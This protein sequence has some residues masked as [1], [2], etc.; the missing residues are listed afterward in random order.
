MSELAQLQRAFL[1][2]LQGVE[3]AS[4]PALLRRLPLEPAHGMTIYREHAQ[5][6]VHDAL[7]AGYPVV[8]RL[9]G[10]AFFAEMARRYGAAHPSHSGDLHAR[11]ERFCAF[12]ATDPP[13]AQLPY[14]S[15]MARLEWACE[16]SLRAADVPPL[17]RA[18]LRRVAPQRHGELRLTLH[19][20]VRLLPCAHA[21][22]A[23]WHAN[24]PGRDGACAPDAGPETILVWREGA[25][26]RVRPIDA[27]EHAFLDA[28]RRG[29]TLEA[30]VALLG[31][32]ATAFL[33]PALARYAAEGV[34][35]GWS[36]ADRG[37]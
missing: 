10:D 2:A 12:I 22:A 1:A 29:E 20:S 15:E 5:A 31:S 28:L 19:P 32:A 6:A 23:I 35:A 7:A 37:A 8:R 17:D 33:A 30:A 25:R 14:L 21:V 11:G 26:V 27:G 36:L 3:D 9:V 4:T 16:E 34:V 13:A 24:Q 18:G